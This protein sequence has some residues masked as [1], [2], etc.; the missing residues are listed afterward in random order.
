MDANG[1]RFEL[2]LGRADWER[3]TDVDV[4]AS[5]Q[6][7][8]VDS[9]PPSEPSN[10]GWDEVQQDLLLR[11]ELQLFQAGASD[12]PVRLEDRRG[13]ACDRF[14]NWFWIS[15][16]RRSI[17]VRNAGDATVRTY[18]PVPVPT[19][20]ASPGDFHPSVPTAPAAALELGGLTI[21]SDHHLVVGLTHVPGFLRFDLQ[22]GGAPRRT[23]WADDLITPFDLAPRRAG[24]FF[25][26]DRQ[27]KRLW[28]FDR[29]FQRVRRGR[30]ASNVPPVSPFVP[31]DASTPAALSPNPESDAGPSDASEAV[32]L[33]LEDPIAIDTLPDGSVLVLD[34]RPS[35]NLPAFAHYRSGVA[36]PD[37][38]GLDLLTHQVADESA[39]EFR[40]EAHD[41]VIAS[42]S[43]TSSPTVPRLFLCSREGNQAF[44]FEIVETSG[45][46]RLVL[47]GDYLPMRRFGGRALAVGLGH[48]GYDSLGNWVPLV[49]QRR[50]RFVEQATFETPVWDS[51]LPDCVWHR[52]LFDGAV[53][54]E[55]QVEI[56]SRASNAEEDLA[57]TEWSAEPSPLRRPDGSELPW[58][59]TEVCVD[60][61]TWE[62]L[63]QR[64]KGRHA[65]L[66]IRLSGN[67]RT[68]P[69]LRA[70][71]IYQPRFSYLRQY[72]PPVYRED[73]TSASFLERLLAN[74]EG[75]WTAIEDRMAAIQVLLDAR[76]APPE[77]LEW[78]AGWFGAVLD[79]VWDE[80]RRRLFLRH[81]M[82]FF[83]YRGTTR[84]LHM[85]L[86]LMFDCR[87]D[88]SIFSADAP[89][90]GREARYRI[91]E[92]FRRRRSLAKTQPSEGS[93]RWYPDLGSAELNRRWREA[94]GSSD[95]SVRY[96]V[97]QPA[98]Q[99]D[100]WIAF[101]Q[102]QL[103]FVPRAD[104]SDVTNWRAFLEQ[105]Y[106]GDIRVLND[107]YGSAWMTFDLI[108][109]P[110]EL[111]AEGPLRED[112]DLFNTE[113][114]GPNGV[115]QESL[116]WDF[117]RRR[118]RN[119]RFLKEAYGS[120]VND[121]EE[122]SLPSELPVEDARVGDWF[123]FEGVVLP[124]HETAHRFTV[125]LPLTSSELQQSDTLRREIL[126]L[127]DRIIRLE[128]PAHTVYD[129]RYFWAAF[130]AGNA[131]LG[132]DT[133]LGPGSRSPDLWPGF[134]LGSRHLSEAFLA[135]R[136]PRD[137]TDRLQVGQDR[138]RRRPL[139]TVNSRSTP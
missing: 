121:F 106:G 77:T 87:P 90:T 82:T 32:S 27:R 61:G 99:T 18:W 84:G 137:C 46:L 54:P 112:W 59:R 29:A 42:G 68:T 23:A 132:E 1:T 66:R 136:P 72:L 111:P 89:M 3:C 55:T 30:G 45:G 44:A 102:A 126:R 88:D 80:S 22:G 33:D 21:T 26:L 123:V 83:A 47:V 51:Q 31:E 79:P 116:W 117:L 11:P 135:A 118:Y 17:Q 35:S 8:W 52:I 85:A 4:R 104:T 73:L 39:D 100:I 69:R 120:G 10:L 63:F 57:H 109:L 62:T 113:I 38:A 43:G 119:I 58:S 6:E 75:Q 138:I 9:P 37:P 139:S 122:I 41:F 56:W 81:A 115:T 114:R 48:A 70:L 5:L 107:T 95:V 2:L 64:A 7:L 19:G 129:V 49:A 53:P 50:P 74:F 65:Q 15:D 76:M 78:L 130:R 16:D 34:R 40:L 12:R 93:N 97:R 71:R 134:E 133:V 14:G 105:R 25:I 131:R 67:G 110:E 103:G 98:S 101:S 24:G 13:A 128:K 20:S 60:R 127:A 28:E 92:R 86:R 96:P 36:L 125:L 91:V 108:P 94:I 124:M